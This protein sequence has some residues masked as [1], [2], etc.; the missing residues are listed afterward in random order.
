MMTKVQTSRDTTHQDSAT[1]RALSSITSQQAQ[2]I[3]QAVHARPQA[4]DVQPID[5]YD[6]YLSILIEPSV[7]DDKQ[8][9]FFISGIA[10]RLEL[11]E[12]HEDSL[13]SV[14]SF[15]HVDGLLA[16]MVDLIGQN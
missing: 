14:A 11:F 1:I 4:W 15:S 13:L 2:T 16:R 5:D 3:T 7:R 8:K 10:Q 9:S 6:G 12:T